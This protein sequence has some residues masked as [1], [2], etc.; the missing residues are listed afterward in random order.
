MSPTD[1]VRCSVKR[2]LLPLLPLAARR[3]TLKAVVAVQGCFRTSVAQIGIPLRLRRPLPPP[4]TFFCA[5]RFW[6]SYKPWVPPGGNGERGGA[7]IKQ[8]RGLSPFPQGVRQCTIYSLYHAR[9]GSGSTT[10]SASPLLLQSRRSQPLRIIPL[11]EAIFI[12]FRG[13]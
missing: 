4:P 10:V 1:H 5:H 12:R 2:K 6:L 7:Y 11:L 3:A 13:P 9:S 8:G